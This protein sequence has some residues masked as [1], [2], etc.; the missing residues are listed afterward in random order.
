MAIFNSYVK[1]PEGN[2]GY[3]SH[4]HYLRGM[5]FRVVSIFHSIPWYS[6]IIHDNVGKTAINPS[7]VITIF[8]GGMEI[9]F[10]EKWVV[11]TWHCF[12][13]INPMKSPSWVLVESR[14]SRLTPGTA[15]PPLVGLK[16]G[17][18]HRTRSES[19]AHHPG[20]W[21][22]GGHITEKSGEWSSGTCN[23]L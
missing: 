9:P 23:I 2:Y 14:L 18:S 20:V 6:I 10:P 5:I 1:L 19:P 7:A 4:K 13:P 22:V 11:F 3:D 8:M 17:R 15:G 16:A 12:T 21:Q